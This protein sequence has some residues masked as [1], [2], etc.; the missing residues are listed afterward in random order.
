VVCELVEWQEMPFPTKQALSDGQHGETS[1]T[2]VTLAHIAMPLADF[3][4]RSGQR[5]DARGNEESWP[6][7]QAVKEF[8]LTTRTLIRA[9]HQ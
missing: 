1:Q 8:T 5:V 9:R 6:F 2:A 4:R 7:H 3:Q